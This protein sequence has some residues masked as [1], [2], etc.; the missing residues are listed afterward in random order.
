MARP[1]LELAADGKEHRTKD[2]T[3]H[4]ANA[5]NLSFEERAETVSSG[6]ARYY[7][8]VGW[9]RAHLIKA[10]LLEAPKHGYLI[11]TPA[12]RELLKN[13]PT[14]ISDQYLRDHYPQFLEN[15]KASKPADESSESQADTTDQTPE[16]Q[17]ESAYQQ[18]KSSLADELLELVKASSPAFFERLVVRLL[19]KMGYGGTIKD[20]GKA[21][22]GS[23]DE[24]ID[25][26]IREDRLG[27]G[28][29][30][31]QAKRYTAG[32]VGRPELQAFVGALTG[33]RARKGIF[34]TTSSFSKTAE[35]Y[36]DS[37]EPRIVLIDGRRLV[38]YM[39]DFGVGVSTTTGYEIKR[40]DSDFFEEG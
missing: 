29:I 3:E 36:V 17:M 31:L 12:G 8:R 26:I 18:L 7:N 22:G 21:I 19:V 38:D 1:L 6:Q 13:P 25:G 28:N 37:I 33:K 11:I 5:L 39:I 9:A 35:E 10:G 20:A 40:V 4:V 24:G 27:L 16:E 34:I 32:N 23:N 2:A 30:Y 14:V 15:W